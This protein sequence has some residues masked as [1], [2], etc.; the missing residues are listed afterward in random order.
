M[1]QRL[2]V[3]IVVS[4]SAC[5]ADDP[6]SIPGRGIWITIIV[7][8][9]IH[10]GRQ[11]RVLLAFVLSSS[12]FLVYLCAIVQDLFFLKVP[13]FFGIQKCIIWDQIHSPRRIL[14]WTNA[15]ITGSRTCRVTGPNICRTCCLRDAAGTCGVA[16]RVTGPKIC[17]TCCLRDA[18]GTC[19]VAWSS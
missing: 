8:E 17:R 9:K 14:S 4:I 10:P 11:K 5:H 1:P 12:L 13:S 15:L 3:S 18:N 19:G 7:C 16:N 6:G 2:R